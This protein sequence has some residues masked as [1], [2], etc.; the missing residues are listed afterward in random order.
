MPLE[1]ACRPN[2][3]NNEDPKDFPKTPFIDEGNDNEN[4]IRS[5]QLKTHHFIFE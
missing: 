4:T 1:T 3:I 5:H 2:L